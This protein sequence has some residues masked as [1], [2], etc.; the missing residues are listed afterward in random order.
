MDFPQI[1][2]GTYADMMK[3]QNADSLNDGPKL[4]RIMS[5]GNAGA[6]TMKSDMQA[7]LVQM[8]SQYE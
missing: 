5:L 2:S 1:K 3:N 8:Q 6:P 4:R 7:K